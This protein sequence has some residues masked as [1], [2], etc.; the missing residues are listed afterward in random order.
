[1]FD[2]ILYVFSTVVAV[3]SEGRRFSNFRPA[4][5]FTFPE[6]SAW[7][8]NLIIPWELREEW[9]HSTVSCSHDDNIVKNG[10]NERLSEIE[11]RVEVEILLGVIFNDAKK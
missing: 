7:T 1:M 3:S 10:V 2:F 9:E 8:F 6:K 5:G 4:V 11:D